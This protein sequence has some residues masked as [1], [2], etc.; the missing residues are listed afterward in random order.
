MPL[1]EEKVIKDNDKVVEVTSEV[2]DNC[3]NDAEVTQK[4]IPMPTP[5][6]PF[7]NDL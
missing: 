3:G 1:N 2:E 5:Q 6:F 7:L 4:F